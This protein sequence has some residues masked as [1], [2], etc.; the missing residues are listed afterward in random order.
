MRT[1]ILKEQ[2]Q[3][4]YEMLNINNEKVT[5]NGNTYQKI[6]NWKSISMALFELNRFKFMGNS[7]KN[8]FNMG[9]NFMASTDITSIS[10][11]DYENFVNLFNIVKAKCEAVI[12]MENSINE[13][14]ENYLY[15][16]LPENLKELDDLNTIVKGIN[17]TF[18]QCPILR[19]TYKEVN[20][21]GVDIGSSWLV[22]S[23]ILTGAS[24]ATKTL[25]W[26]AD[27]IKKCNDIRIQNRTIKK[28]DLEYLISKMEFDE[29]KSKEL[30]NKVEKGIEDEHQKLYIQEFENIKIPIDREISVE[31]KAKIVHCM[32]TM[33]DLLE[34]GVELY[35]S[36]NSSE[37]LKNAFPKKEE[38]KK[39]S[40]DLKLL[41]DST[42]ENKIEK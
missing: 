33:I 14:D 9:A 40:G 21:V 31:E 10:I 26:I 25:N 18:N 32:S 15:I 16:K 8:I 7:V 22:I 2:V 29:K 24:I 23:F 12:N 39:I 17:T 28:M 3:E 34:M 6:I 30:L 4:Y 42:I 19:D 20:F 11:N 13:D 5:V 27:F 1:A 35:P 36:L 37:E 38:W 41:K